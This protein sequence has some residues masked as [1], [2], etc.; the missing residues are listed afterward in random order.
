MDIEN[1]RSKKFEDI[2]HF[3][4]NGNEYWNAR[5]LQAILEYKEWRNFSDAIDRAMVSCKL[6]EQE[7]KYH[8]V[9]VTKMVS[10]GSGSERKVDDF[11]LTRFACYLIVMNGDPRKEPIAQGQMYFAVKTRLQEIQELYGHLDE[12]GK[13]LFRRSDIRQKNMLLY[14]AA[15][16]AGIQTVYEYA[17]FTDKGYMG[18]YGE[19]KK[20]DIAERKGIGKD[21]DILDHMGS[22][23]LAA[24]LFRISQTE[25][26]L[27]KN[28]VRDKET[29]GETHY[30]VGKE[31]RTAIERIGGTMPED[32]PT[33][34][35][36]IPQLQREEIKRIRSED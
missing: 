13:R 35:K 32:L 31:V 25:E 14:E 21:Q 15:R 19:L 30:M 10:L 3:D 7:P 24:N 36:S 11:R 1:W 12:D 20:K 33:P 16:K 34:E 22:V 23:E 27:K 26:A 6:N 4:G 9:N 8:F 18:L 17:A 2:K 28:G 29:A 5:E